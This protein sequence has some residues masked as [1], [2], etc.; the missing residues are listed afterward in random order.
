MPRID[1][2]RIKRTLKDLK[3]AK[4]FTIAQFVLLLKCSVPSARLKLKEWQVFTSYNQN[5][6]YY[7]LPSEPCFDEN[8]LWHYNGIFFSRHGN[9]KKTVVYLVH[10]SESGLSG[11]QIEKLIGL[12]FRSFLHHF[13]N[14]PEIRREKSK[15]VYTYFSTQPE[16]YQHQLQNRIYSVTHKTSFPAEIDAI[17]ILVALIKHHNITVDQIMAL[18]E[19]KSTKLTVDSIRKFL[20]H[21]GLKKKIPDTGR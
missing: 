15:G 21:Y 11:E 13:R 2:D 16:R 4:V 8:G 1:T 10:K 12:S 20:E 19:V 6:S 7:T 9:L 14:V 5:G 17:L 3:K 18:P